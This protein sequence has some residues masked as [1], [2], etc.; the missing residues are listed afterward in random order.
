MI[1]K[2]TSKT[3]TARGIRC[4]SPIITV[5]VLAVLLTAC[6]DFFSNSMAPWAAR[7]PDKL[8]PAITVDNIDELLA[9]AEND[10]ELSMAIL[11]K[12][13]EAVDHASGGDKLKLQNAAMEAAVNAAGLGQAVLGA[14]G[15]LTSLEGDTTEEDAKKMVLD[16]VNG[17]KNLEEAGSVLFDTLPKPSDPNFSDFTDTAS[18]DDLALAAVVLLAGEVKKNGDDMDNYV[19]HYQSGPTETEELAMALAIAAA[20]DSREDELSGPLKDAL[21]GLN[22]I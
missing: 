22:L 11:K 5:F 16:A 3:R 7:N 10:P 14:A 9:M 2:K 15:K 19:N 4:L 18:A 1:F 13:K 6:R 20:L 17:M 8:I 12:L 21:K